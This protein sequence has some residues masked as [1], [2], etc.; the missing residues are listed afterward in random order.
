MEL[1]G[2]VR[3]GNGVNAMTNVLGWLLL[4]FSV[5][6]VGVSIGPALH[7][8]GDERMTHIGVVGFFVAI[9]AIGLA[10]ALGKVK[11]SKDE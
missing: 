10:L 7:T 1:G 3:P 9:G 8:K 4:V 11:T 6:A 2:F 5:L